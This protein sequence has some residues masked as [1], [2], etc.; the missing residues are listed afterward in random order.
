MTTQN[1]LEL[2]N[3]Y[4]DDALTADDRVAVDARLLA[5]PALLAELD[6]LRATA[7]LIR[8]L[9]K[10]AAPRNF[11]LTPAQARAARQ[12]PWRLA[13]A[14][15]AAAV[16]IVFAAALA[17][18]RGDDTSI[19]VQV[20]AVATQPAPSDLV[21]AER[22]AER[23]EENMAQAPGTQAE[24]PLGA[25]VAAMPAMSATLA[26]SLVPQAT[27]LADNTQAPLMTAGTM[28]DALVAPANTDAAVSAMSAME[29]PAAAEIGGAASEASP[30]VDA[31]RA[32]LL[33]LIAGL[34]AAVRALLG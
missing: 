5:E 16:V 27:G 31:A 34:L 20:A 32:A 24:T 13:A 29:V 11:T 28:A 1:D 15:A 8:S 6:G 7:A 4:L 10:L 12:P 21:A 2:L 25:P 17:L 33:R 30:K 9:P 14:Y 3:A 22:S 18:A 23:V 26:P 19:A